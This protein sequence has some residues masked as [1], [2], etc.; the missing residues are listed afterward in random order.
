MEEQELTQPSTAST[1]THHRARHCRRRRALPALLAAALPLA[2]G[3]PALADQLDTNTGLSVE[4]RP[5]VLGEPVTF[6]APVRAD[7]GPIAGTVTFREGETVLGTVDLP[8]IAAGPGS[9]ATGFDHTCALTEAGGV[10]CWGLNSAGSL[11]DGTLVRRLTPVPVQ[12]LERGIV[13]VTVGRSHSCALGAGGAVWCWG[14]N[15]SG[16]LGDGTTER[17]MTPT[18]VVGLPPGGASA[19]TANEHHTCAL[20]AADGTA[21]CW[22]HNWAGQIGDGTTEDRLVPT[23]VEGLGRDLRTISAGYYHTCALGGNGRAFCWGFN[24]FG[25]L[26]DGTTTRRLTPVPVPAL[27]WQ[28]HA[29]SAGF[30]HSCALDRNGRAFCWG[31]NSWGQ[32]GDGTTIARLTPT[33]VQTPRRGMTDITTGSEHSCAITRP[34]RVICWG[35]DSSGQLGDGSGTVQLTPVRARTRSGRPIQAVSGRGLHSCAVLSVGVVRCW[36]QN[37]S[38]QLGVG[39]TEARPLPTTVVGGA[40]APAVGRAL[41]EFT[42]SELPRGRRCVTAHY[43]GT[44]DFA[45]S[46]SP[47]RCLRIRPAPMH[48]IDTP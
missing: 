21:W 17:R 26:G 16:Q 34:G 36:G 1:R 18:R 6:T 29:I 40:F 22:G 38:G 28:N 48:A 39:D 46:V 9:L 10:F 42:T 8:G 32:L 41:A 3:L 27:G 33:R 5:G 13:A 12:G 4:P 30:Y 24:S 31:Y 15:S 2:L 25:Q 11:G 20:A 23:P 14:A 19:I 43:E 35:R 47:E 45:P 44:D 7:D 37:T